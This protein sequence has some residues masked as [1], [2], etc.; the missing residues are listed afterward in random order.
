[1][2]P[3]LR[4]RFGFVCAMIV[5]GSPIMAQSPAVN[6][7]K[8]E[9]ELARQKV[10]PAL[11]N[12]SVVARFFNGGRT[13][14]APAGGSG[15]IV[16]K[17][18]YVLTNFH[19]A[20]NTTRIVCTL[21]TGEA[22]EAKVVLHDPLTDLSVL[23]LMLEKREDPALP[24]PFANLGDSD[25]VQVGDTVMSMGNP[26]LLSSSMTLGIVS[27]TKRVF[28]DFTGTQIQEQELDEGER[29]GVF[30]RWIQHDALILPG[31]SGGPL[32]NA[33]AEVVGINEL[34]GNGIGFAIPSNIAAKVLKG[35]I[36]KGSMTRGWIGVTV[37]PVSKMGRTTGSLVASVVPKSPADTAGV[38]AGDVILEVDGKPANTRFFE[39]VPLF[40]QAIADLA[41]GANVPIKLL[42]KNDMKDVSVTIALMEKY[43]GLEEEVRQI[44]ATLQE[45]T[46]AM[47]RNRRLVDK[48]GVMVTGV[49]SGF[50]LEGA[51]P[52][53]APGDVILSIGDVKVNSLTEVRKA[54]AKVGHEDFVVGIR[55]RREEMVSVAKI[56]D[57]APNAEGTELPKAWLGVR[58]QV[59]TAEIAKALKMPNVKGLRVTEIYPGTAIAKAG[60][61]VGDV[62]TR[63]NNDPI[64][65]FRPQDAEDLRRLMED[66]PIGKKAAL[67]V[68]RSMKPVVLNFVAEAQAQGSDLAKSAKQKEFEFSVRDL[69]PLDRIE[70]RLKS[71]VK[72]VIVTDAVIGGWAQIAGLELDDIIQSIN[73]QLVDNVDMFEQVMKS[74]MQQHP[75][76]VQ[77]FV[78]RGSRTHF[79]F[80]EPDWNKIA[81]TR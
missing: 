13:Q 64:N 77:I 6:T 7:A 22:I 12:I 67:H 81:E 17:E 30:T 60:L 48:Q 63:L 54:L 49:R 39:E 15:V 76:I 46:E 28:T 73:G 47:V 26:L 35:A 25:A 68:L 33:Q 11:V 1:M 75:K 57:D 69:M 79:L 16:N 3:H 66:L 62:I 74:A 36:E 27:N 71:T 9:V 42:R 65:S 59:M 23:K 5:L 37:L 20:G 44:G 58:T 56:P 24:L 29:T 72:G 50:P 70:R 19:V 34:G 43:L 40:Y 10:Y 14:R 8:K 32:V 38:Q 53:I 21:I 45:I 31:N 4:V 41:V 61:Q 18:G 80:I 55:R 2:S 51:K 52:A 78:Q